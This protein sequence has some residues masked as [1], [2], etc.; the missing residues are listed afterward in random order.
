MGGSVCWATEGWLRGS[1]LGLARA[2]RVRQNNQNSQ[3]EPGMSHGISGS[4]KAGAEGELK[5]AFRSSL[6]GLKLF[7]C[8]RLTALNSASPRLD[9]VYHIAGTRLSFQMFGVR[10]KFSGE[11]GRHA[12]VGLSDFIE[13]RAKNVATVPQS[14]PGSFQRP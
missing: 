11:A 8:N 10:G 9:F 7:I 6:P 3:N 14:C 1:G 13:K 2:L 5:P 4:K 12:L